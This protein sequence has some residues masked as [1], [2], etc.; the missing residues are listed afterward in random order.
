MILVREIQQQGLD[1]LIEHLEE[2][3]KPA[4]I[5]KTTDVKW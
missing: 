4:D 2:E 5:S 3:D 1:S